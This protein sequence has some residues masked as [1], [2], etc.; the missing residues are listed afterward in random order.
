MELIWKNVH[1]L[2]RLQKKEAYPNHCMRRRNHY[3]KVQGNVNTW[4]ELTKSK[5]HSRSTRTT[6]QLHEYPYPILDD[7]ERIYP[8]VDEERIIIPQPYAPSDQFEAQTRVN[9][10]RPPTECYYV[11]ELVNPDLRALALTG[12][13][14]EFGK[15]LEI[16]LETSDFMV[17]TL[18]GELMSFAVS[19]DVV[20][21]ERLK[22]MIASK[23]EYI[24]SHALMIDAFRRMS[25]GF[26]YLTP[27]RVCDNDVIIWLAKIAARYVTT[28]VTNFNAC[29]GRWN[30]NVQMWILRNLQ[31]TSYVEAA[32]RSLRIRTRPTQPLDHDVTSIDCSD[33]PDVYDNSY[34]ISSSTR[35]PARSSSTLPTVNYVL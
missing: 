13:E 25:E 17:A 6:H 24:R 30:K 11:K 8:H 3:V 27:R 10:D 20:A 34:V 18:K 16:F 23:K 28:K 22:I 4:G 35:A 1:H 5:L 33:V 2:Q 26:S 12:R 29:I 14:I 32:S 19:A 9:V 31:G 7:T 21:Q 15:T